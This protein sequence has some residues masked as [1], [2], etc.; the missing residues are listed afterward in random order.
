MKHNFPKQSAHWLL[1]KNCPLQ[2]CQQAPGAELKRESP[3][4]RLLIHAFLC[5]Q[6]RCWVGWALAVGKPARAHGWGRTP[7]SPPSQRTEAAF[8]PLD[9]SV[10]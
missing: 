5:S 2:A 10:M 3:T 1:K 6:Q 4:L 8:L 7:A 9:I